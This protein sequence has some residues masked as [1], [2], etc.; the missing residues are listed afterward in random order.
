MKRRDERQT[1]AF[2]CAQQSLHALAHLIGGFVC[3]SDGEDVPV[4]TFF[5]AMR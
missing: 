1:R 2:L 4:G 5:S 3:E